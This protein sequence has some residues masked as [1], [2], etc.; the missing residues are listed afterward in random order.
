MRTDILIIGCGPAGLQAAIHAARKKVKVT[1]IGH[2]GNSAISGHKV[3]NYFGVEMGDGEELVREAMKKAERFGAELLEE[4]VTAMERLDQGFLVRTDHGTEVEAT[5][6]ILAPGISRRKLGVKGEKDFIGKGVSYCA[7]CDCNFFRGRP[8]AVV[9][10]GSEAASSAMLLTGYASKVY[11]VAEEVQVAD[12]L[13]DRVEQSQV[14]MVHPAEVSRI[15]GEKTVT[16]IELE[17][18]R[19]LQVNGVFIELGAKSSMELALEIDLVPDPSGHIPVDR[20]CRT[21]IDSVFACG[22]VTG[23]PWQL[24]KAV[25]EGCVAGTNAADL[26]KKK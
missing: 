4:D 25:G 6:I 15:V 20:D 12:H 17:D 14:E 1:L 3:E 10:E 9:G 18:G 22:D 2:P 5:A 16:G 24:A 7:S 11:W 19:T 13:M 8:V 23:Q 21:S 26:I